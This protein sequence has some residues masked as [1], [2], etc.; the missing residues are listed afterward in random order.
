LKPTI[1]QQSAAYYSMAISML[2]IVSSRSPIIGQEINKFKNCWNK[3]VRILEVLK[4]LFKQ[5]LNMSSS[6]RDM[7]GPILGDMS[8][9]R[10]SQGS[11]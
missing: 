5:F 7:S 11:E 4:L 2:W 1:G 8:N 3:S 10:W 9:N 6:Q